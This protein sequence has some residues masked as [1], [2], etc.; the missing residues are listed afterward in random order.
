MKGGTCGADTRDDSRIGQVWCEK[1]ERM[2]TTEQTLPATRA[3]P[4]EDTPGAP[5]Y[6]PIVVTGGN[7]SHC[8]LA[9]EP[10]QLSRNVASCAGCMSFIN[11]SQVMI[12]STYLCATSL[13]REVLCPFQNIN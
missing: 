10:A 2:H 3:H 6:V 4:R 9:P 5:K 11:P 7:Y 13:E 8:I 12:V 1:R